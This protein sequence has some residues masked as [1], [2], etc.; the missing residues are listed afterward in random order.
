MAGT[1]TLTKVLHVRENEKKVAQKDYAL[2]ME[3]FETL[4]T[5]LYNLLKKKEEAETL[6]ENYIQSTTPIEKMRQLIDYQEKL[7]EQILLVQFQVQ[8]AREDM[9]QKQSRLTEAHVEVKK[10]EK[11]IEIRKKEEI[12][13]QVRK[14]KAFMDELSI[15]QFLSHK[16]G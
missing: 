15:N 14:E 3:K 9:E 8:L 5:E 13:E 2:S 1:M 7:T 12:E 4:A 11:V 16:N 6:Y 10:Y